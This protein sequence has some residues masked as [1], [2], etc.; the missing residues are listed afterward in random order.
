VLRGEPVTGDFGVVDLAAQAGIARD[1]AF[2]GTSALLFVASAAGTI[3][4]CGSMSAGM[5]MA[6]GW[7]MSMAWMRM[8]GQT[9][10]GAA[11]SF[12]GMWLVMMVAMML[13][14]LVAML[15]SYR[16]AVRTGSDAARL[17]RLT[18]LVGAG[19]FFVWAVFGA[20]A[21]PLGVVLAAA[22]MRWP[23]LARSVPI[24]TG[25]VLLLAGCL[26]LTPWKLR[27]LQCCR[28][29]PACGAPVQSERRTALRH[30][31]RLGLHCALCCS[32]FMMVLLVTDVMNLGA[33]GMVATAITVERL[34]PRPLAAA[35]ASGVVVVAAGALMIARAL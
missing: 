15:L 14:S 12:L 35:R 27:Q 16:W 5:P 26:Q 29:A 21:Y 10:L 32:A 23:A 18:A 33:M 22:E 31:L 8:P 9:W 17:G 11:G 4:S 1:R 3:Y 2:L 30:G 13:P 20:V 28:D 6:G 34:A 19:Y 7:T 24:A 25:V